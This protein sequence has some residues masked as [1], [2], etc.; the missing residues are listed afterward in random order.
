[1]Q[2]MAAAMERTD[3]TIVRSEENIVKIEG[4]LVVLTAK[5]DR[6]A[7]GMISLELKLE[8]TTGK[9]NAL[10]DTVDGIIRKKPE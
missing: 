3:G 8:E 6:F 7:E 2:K 5:L 4:A 9:L 1:M 10:I